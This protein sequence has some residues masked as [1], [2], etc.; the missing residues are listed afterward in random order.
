MPPGYGSEMTPD[1]AHSIVVMDDEHHAG[2][3]AVAALT[4]LIR[5]REGGQRAVRLV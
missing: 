3:L 2:R 1:G 4:P 5:P